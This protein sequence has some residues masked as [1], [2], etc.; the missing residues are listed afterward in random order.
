M[1]RTRSRPATT[2]AENDCANAP[3]PNPNH[4]IEVQ[5]DALD[6]QGISGW[7][8]IPEEPTNSLAVEVSVNSHIIA[9]GNANLARPDVAA[10]GRGTG[11][12]GFK[13][14]FTRTLVSG[15]RPKIRTI[16]RLKGRLYARDLELVLPSEM[17]GISNIA[18][19]GI[20]VDGF[21][22]EMTLLGASGWAW[23]PG[24]PAISV[25]VEAV[26]GNQSLGSTTANILRPDLKA[27][28]KGTGLYG[29]HLV[30]D[31]PFS[32]HGRPT[33]R[34]YSASEHV[35]LVEPPFDAGSPSTDRTGAVEGRIEQLSPNRAK[36]W[37]W[38]PDQ[39]EVP[40]NVRVVIDGR[41]VGQG[42]A[43]IMRSDLFASR[44]GTG[45]YGFELTFRETITEIERLTVEVLQ[46]DRITLL[47]VL[48]AALQGQNA[49]PLLLVNTHN[50]PEKSY[51]KFELR[52][53]KA[54]D[55][56]QKPAPRLEASGIHTSDEATYNRLSSTKACVSDGDDASRLYGFID[57]MTLLGAS[58]WAWIPGS[59][60]ISVKVEAV[61]GNQS[62]GSTTANILRP[63]LKAAGK[64]TGLYGFHLVF[65]QPFSGHGRPTLRAYSASEHV[66]LVEPPFDAGSPSTD[67]TGAVEGRIEQL[68]PNRA[69][70]WVWL[71]D[72]PEV[73]VNVRVVIDGRAVGQGVADIMRSDLF[74]S[75][76]GTGRYGFELTFRETITEIERLTV[77]VLQEDRI[78]LLPVLPA[79]L[80]RD[81]SL[82]EPENQEAAA[83]VDF[84]QQTIPV[85]AHIDRLSRLDATGWAWAP[86]MPDRALRVE[87]VLDGMVIGQAT[88]SDLR[89]DLLRH[90]IGTGLYGF[91]IRFLRPI[92][93]ETVPHFR[94]L[95]PGR[96]LYPSSSFLN[97]PQLPPSLRPMGPEAR[98]SGLLAEHSYFTS[99]GPNFEEHDPTILT[100]WPNESLCAPVIIA[101]YLPQFHSIV[102][103]DT[104]WGKGFTEWRQLPRALSRFPGHYQPR[105][106][107]DLGFYDPTNAKHLRAQAAMARASGISAFA[108]YYYWFNGQRVLERPIE[109]LLKSEIEMPFILIWANENWT[110]TWDGSESEVLLH[111][112]Y[113]PEDETSLLDDWARHFAD[114]RYLRIT[115][116]PLFCIYN[117][118]AIPNTKETLLRWRSI[119]QDR[120]NVEPLFFMCQTFGS[121]DPRPFGLDGAMEFPPHKLAEH[122]TPRP[123]VDAYSPEYRGQIFSYDDFVSA[124]LDEVQPHY[125]LIK[126][127]VPGWD[128]DPRRPNR[129]FSVEGSSPRRYESWLYNL[130]K[131]A[132]DNPISDTPIVAVNAWNEW[133]EC[134][135]LE[136]DVHYGAAYLNAT[137]R[138]LHTVI[139]DSISEKPDHEL[140]DSKVSVVVP[141]YN[142]ESYIIE[143]LQSIVAQTQKPDEILFLDDCSCDKSLS[144]AI[145][146]LESCQIDY[147]VIVN[148]QNSGNVFKQWIKGI[149]NARND[150]I[151]IAES[152]DTADRKFLQ[153]LLPAFARQETLLA[154]GW[155]RCIGTDGGARAD[156]NGYFDE[157]K[158][159]CWARSVSI[160]AF[161]AFRHDFAIKNVIPNVSGAVFRKPCLT[162]EEITRLCNYRF[163]GDWYF[164]GLISRGGQIAYRHHA[165]SFFRVGELSVSRNAFFKLQHI[166]EHAMILK[167]LQALYEPDAKALVDH[168]RSLL[169]HFPD[170]TYADLVKRLS[171]GA[172][173]AQPPRKLRICI[174]AHSFAIGGGE[175]VPLELANALKQRGHHITYLVMEQHVAAVQGTLRKRLQ[176][177]IAIVHWQ[178]V[179]GD[180]PGFFKRYGLQVLN[181]H[182]ISVESRLCAAS[183]DIQVPYIGSLHGGYEASPEYATPELL[184][185]ASRNV[186]KWFYLGEKN[187]VV[188][189]TA[190]VP[191]DRF[192]RSF[193]ALPEAI[194]SDLNTDSFRS[195]YNVDPNAF[196]FVICSRASEDKGWQIAVDVIARLNK[197]GYQAHLVLIGDGPDAKGLR[198]R[199]EYLPFVTFLGH[200]NHPSQLLPC[201]DL[202]IFPS[203]FSGETFPLFLL[204][205]FR[206]RLPVISTDIGEIP[207]ILNQHAEASPGIMVDHRQSR[208]QIVRDMVDA[209]IQ[210]IENAKTFDSMRKQTETTLRRF[211]FEALIDQYESVFSGLVE[212]SA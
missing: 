206:A 63:D 49:Q 81:Q 201:F 190:G 209:A 62:L 11:R 149:E 23:I 43:D 154:F 191:E 106:P 5:V 21:I 32:G 94:L 51:S 77:E 188:L 158:T 55:V 76:R 113:R 117:P 20:L 42:V 56:K 97:L 110:R 114:R 52:A 7:T 28:G 120:Y 116:R 124:S 98:L 144:L 183:Q 156:L 126:T 193:N 8:W 176:S 30:F 79:A 95:I 195:A 72:Q 17:T 151:W 93:G 46:E 128:N 143:R 122:V 189:V 88:A 16:R 187:K 179:C 182:N 130:L 50:L 48:P 74:A 160:P 99:E 194:D 27:A 121:R 178:D 73:P 152:D 89:L 82:Y 3:S 15:D 92:L 132:I 36:G 177:G 47:P 162:L 67:R 60:A 102:E 118:Q 150:L 35:D 135:Y 80:Q 38:L 200:V 96:D 167:D 138:A 83:K 9:K 147:K 41:A 211:S 64:G 134:A 31:Q 210:V 34:A 86:G 12:Y 18:S 13:L 180:L 69:K 105:I 2:S 208:E 129:G 171:S 84:R 164:Y 91:E 192:V 53:T 199:N 45:R 78:T 104:F 127:V 10:S 161:T 163:A 59:P 112:D 174:A 123:P 40:V 19:G 202:G 175:L 111:Q 204:E 186:D 184:A 24:S 159:F 39:P 103:N 1:S 173:D 139:R 101:F 44:R 37:V 172:P 4:D 133:G 33:L 108:F 168:V 146:F 155:I 119:L 148:E 6:H 137:A 131:R 68:S 170:L 142:H 90:G 212:D 136:P 198:Q 165:H 205:C 196:I 71:P 109:R 87:A 181:S 157:L 169:V 203:L 29:F 58:G 65:D 140:V 107:R 61:F 166:N 185:Y 197:R 70:G 66:D 25:K 153:H 14:R 141:N 54:L 100:G 75:R 125:P 207:Y 57:E 85:E 145:E 115:N 22:D 26:F